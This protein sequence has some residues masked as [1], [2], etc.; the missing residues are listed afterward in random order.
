MKHGFMLIELII[1]TLIASMI[2]TLLLTALSQGARFQKTVDVM[3]DMSLRIGIFSNQ[4]E[5]DFTGAFIPMQARLKEEK[6]EADETE[7]KKEGAATKNEK[8]VDATPEKEVA[9]KPAEKPLEKIFYG[10][11]KENHLDTLTFVT[12]NPLTVFV[13]K[14]VGVVK[15]KIVRVQYTL[16]RENEKDKESPFVL[17][18]QE[19]NELDLAKYTNVRAY[20]LL[21]GIKECI[22]TYIAR[23]EKEDE[24]EK[25]AAATT[26]KGAPEKQTAKQEKPK[27]QYEYKLLK[28]WQSEPK[29]KTQAEKKEETNFPRIPYMIEIKMTL[30]DIQRTK[31]EDFVFTYQLPI[32]ISPG[33]EKEPEKKEEAKEKTKANDKQLAEKEGAE[34]TA[35]L[36]IDKK[37]NFMNTMTKT[38]GNITKIFNKT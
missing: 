22:I 31:T 5:K 28:E 18:R 3:V 9:K 24:K 14:D 10:T 23:I 34:K 21:S 12:N 11:T 6:E 36:N 13:G 38:M 19:S 29:D 27:I 15:P 4:F 16:K 1:V 37:D 2:G 8:S 35:Q 32:D 26:T 17:M 7:T 30:W 33:K 25:Q 20:E